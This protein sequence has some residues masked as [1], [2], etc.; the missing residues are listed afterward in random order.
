MMK[1]LKW[2]GAV[3]LT[4][5]CMNACF[6]DDYLDETKDP[7]VPEKPEQKPETEKPE[8]EKPE[9]E[10]PEFTGPLEL[11]VVG[12]YLKDSEGNIV[13]LH[14]FGQ[15][16]S[17]FFNNFAWNDYDVEG[18][19]RHNKSMID[20]ILAAGWRM[21]FIRMHMDPYWSDDIQGVRKVRRT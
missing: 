9:T 3:A 16:Y 10:I 14:G 20:Q 7:V 11:N 15:T 4:V 17:P 5:L 21:N 19:L 18:C 2:A 8:T 6:P 1:L 13:N 12:R